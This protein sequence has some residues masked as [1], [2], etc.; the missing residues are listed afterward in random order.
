MATKSASQHHN[1]WGQ[2]ANAASLPGVGS[3]QDGLEAGDLAYSIADG[4]TFTCTSTA[5]PASWS[6]GGGGGGGDASYP[7]INQWVTVDKTSGFYVADGTIQFPENSIA[8]VIPIAAA[9]IPSAA[10]RVGIKLMPGHYTEA[11]LDLPSY[12]YLVGESREACF[13]TNAAP[14]QL[15]TQTNPHV[16]FCRVSFRRTG[17]DMLSG[18]AVQI[19]AD[20]F[21][22]VGAGVEDVFFDDVDCDF[23]ITLGVGVF[24][25][26]T[27]STVKFRHSM[28]VGEYDPAA[29]GRTFDSLFVSYS[30]GAQLHMVEFDQCVLDGESA[31]QAGAVVFKHCQVYGQVWIA[32]PYGGFA[33][34]ATDAQVSFHYTRVEFYDFD[35]PGRM[36][37]EEGAL[38]LCTTGK[39]VLDHSVFLGASYDDGCS[40]TSNNAVRL[41]TTDTVP[42]RLVCSNCRFGYGLPAVHPFGIPIHSFNVGWGTAPYAAGVFSQCTFD[43]GAS[44]LLINDGQDEFPCGPGQIYDSASMA[45]NAVKALDE[46]DK[47]VRLYGDDPCNVMSA[48]PVARRVTLDLNGFI[49][50]EGGT[51]IYPTG[52]QAFNIVVKNGKFDGASSYGWSLFNSPAGS[53]GVWDIEFR[54]IEI[55][56][57][58]AKVEIVG[59]GAGAKIRFDNVRN[60]GG[61]N[62]GAGAAHWCIRMSDVDPEV[63][64]RGSYLKGRA[65]SEAVQFDNFAHTK[66]YASRSTFLHGSL[67]ANNPFFGKFTISQ[68]SGDILLDYCRC[69]QDPTTDINV[70][71]I[72]ESAYNIFNATVDF[73][74]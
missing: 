15:V 61:Y 39:V 31:F 21:A 71:L 52:S 50:T 35:Q 46:H 33:P 18:Y 57:D 43:M 25:A 69:N 72:A 22:G 58:G 8:N 54:D 12:V 63:Q 60:W 44:S 40:F 51:L 37:F 67:G 65:A 74:G 23:D 24:G 32:D 17:T 7:D 34:T 55:G 28:I 3:S 9:L 53:T 20:D 16:G 49:A 1:H 38:G 64:I 36:G 26:T 4:A 45:M 68:G 66:F 14:A 10:N 73:L 47:V 62:S 11:D 19:G 6:S 29:M 56:D 41:L 13:I 30:S 2:F 59:G 70:T 27:P 48:W 5:F 42:S